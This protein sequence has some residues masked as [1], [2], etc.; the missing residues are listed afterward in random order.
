MN[1]LLLLA[2]LLLSAAAHANDKT[3]YLHY[4][5]NADGNCALTIDRVD[6]GQNSDP[7]SGCTSSNAPLCAADSKPAAC[8]C[9]KKDDKVKW[10]LSK[11]S[12][13]GDGVQ[14]T[15]TFTAPTDAT[16]KAFS[17]FKNENQCGSEFSFTNAQN[18]TLGDFAYFDALSFEY[19]VVASNGV[20]R[21]EEGSI[22]CEADPRIVVEQ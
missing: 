15:L 5:L 14:F 17:P 19:Q 11:D 9:G 7:D 6:D 8:V 20:A 2:A 3:L 16:G 1:R 10:K 18:C 4:S 13:L 22:Y 12:T 21:G